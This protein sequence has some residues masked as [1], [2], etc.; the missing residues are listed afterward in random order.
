M[1]KQLVDLLQW[2]HYERHGV[3]NNQRL[4]CLHIR[5]FRRRSKKESK[6]RVTGLCEGNSLATAEFTAQSASNAENVSI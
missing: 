1:Y 2:Y 5:L 6:L 4:D 3:S